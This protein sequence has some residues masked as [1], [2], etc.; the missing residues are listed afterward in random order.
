MVVLFGSLAYT[1]VKR[2]EMK[3]DFSRDA[4]QSDLASS[5]VTVNE[6]LTSVD[7]VKLESGESPAKSKN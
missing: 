7:D 1:H 6:S 2:Q 4:K 3:A 5:Q